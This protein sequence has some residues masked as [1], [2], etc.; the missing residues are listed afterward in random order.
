MSNYKLK[1]SGEKIDE[2]LTKA[3]GMSEVVPATG[4]TAGKVKLSDATDSESDASAG[5]AATP[6]AVKAAFDAASAA[7]EVAGDLSTKVE[8]NT[9]AITEN[10]TAV[11]K[12]E[13]DIDN[14]SS[15]KISKFYASSQGNT[16]LPDSDNGKI[17]DL[18]LY[19]KGSQ[20][21]Y[22]GKNLLSALDVSTSTKLGVTVKSAGAGE[23]SVKGTA[24][25]D[26]LFDYCGQEISVPKGA[27]VLCKVLQGTGS[28]NNTITFF[29]ANY[30]NGISTKFGDVSSSTAGTDYKCVLVRIGIKSGETVDCTIGLSLQMDA[31]TDYE[32]YVGGIPSPNP[33][34]PQEIKSVV[35]PSV[36][37]CGKNLLNLPDKSSTDPPINYE[38]NKGI[39][40]FSGTLTSGYSNIVL[41]EYTIPANGEYTISTNSSTPGKDSPRLIF[42]VNGAAYESVIPSKSKTF[43]AGDNVLVVARISDVGN[44][45]G[46]KI[47]PMIEK[48]STATDYQPYTEQTATLPYT[49]NAI[50][51]TSG[52]NVTID[53]QQYIADYVDVER[54]KLVRMCKEIDLK[55]SAWSIGTNEY[56]GYYISNAFYDI[57]CPASNKQ[58]ANII[59]EKYKV[60]T[61]DDIA[62]SDVGIA[63]SFKTARVIVTNQMSGLPDGKMVYIL[64]TPTEI[65][66][67]ADEI[68]AFKALVSYYP[69]TNVSTTSEQL[70]GYTVFNYPISLAN[71]WN[72]VKQQI[73]DTRDYLYDIDLVTAE[74]YVNSAYATALAEMEI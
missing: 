65:D 53:E 74:A 66:L 14:L 12:L 28:A 24:T 48:S 35:K 25:A 22:S 5:V 73:G 71:G 38:I 61:W 13:K 4:E 29:G 52:G 17:I 36:K 45:D 42:S 19:G 54:G 6:K 31:S 40:T 55:N 34:Y 30:K 27:R 15:S 37:V 20:Q 8:E 3:D 51:V 62:T 57:S 56:A 64:A 33:E 63:V 21:Q 70:D 72:Y 49:L 11:D 32:P 41:S 69:V 39:V 23:I 26:A 43:R 67:T 44:Y 10:A 60:F 46:V 2:I 9:T 50:P 7:G 18:K 59:V 68:A 16:N 1:Y 58:K 47:A